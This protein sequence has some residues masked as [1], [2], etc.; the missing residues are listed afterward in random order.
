MDYFGYHAGD[1]IA[2]EM[3]GAPSVEIHHIR[4][5]SLEKKAENKIENLAALCRSCHEKAHA[6]KE[7]TERLK[8]KHRRNVLKNGTEPAPMDR[9]LDKPTI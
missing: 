2:C 6:S 4:P 7:F 3:C 5:R 9:Y 8:E 1:F